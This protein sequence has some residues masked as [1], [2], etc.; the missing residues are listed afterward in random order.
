MVVIILVFIQMMNTNI[1]DT[2]VIVISYG[3]E[4]IFRIINK[5]TKEIV[6]DILLK[7]LDI[8]HMWDNFKK[9][10]FMKYLKIK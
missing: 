6:Q 9:N 2:G 8:V 10:L 4:R 1:D 5:K 7:N 3:G